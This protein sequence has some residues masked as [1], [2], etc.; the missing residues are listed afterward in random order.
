MHPI[1]PIIMT[2]GAILFFVGIAVQARLGVQRIDIVKLRG[3]E[4]KL[5]K[6]VAAMV[7]SGVALIM[8]SV[9]IPRYIS[10]QPEPDSQ[11]HQAI[12]SSNQK[13]ELESTL[14]RLNLNNEAMKTAINRFQVEY[15]EAAQR[16]DNNTM[17][18]LILEFAYRIRNE[19][20]TRNYPEN[21]IEREAERMTS[22][23]KQTINQK[24]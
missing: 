24:E 6:F 18:L 9:L 17:D 3:K 4:Y 5:W 19:L 23:L 15:Q 20:Q 12:L 7:G 10:Y 11:A 14:S 8:I 22:I 21:Q 13:Y 16:G 1:V 2:I